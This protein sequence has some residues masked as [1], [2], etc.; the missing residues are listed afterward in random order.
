MFFLFIKLII[1]VYFLV[2]FLRS[3][4]LVWGVGLLSVTTAVLLD[5]F[6][7]TFNRAE[8]LG[9][10]GF[11]F[12][13]LAGGVFGGLAI[14][15]WGVL[16]PY[17]QPP[18]TAVT[19]AAPQP[20]LRRETFQKPADGK[21]HTA[22]DR[23]MLYEEIYKRFGQEDFLDL[24]FD[25]GISDLDLFVGQSFTDSIPEILSLAEKR[26]QTTALALAVERI[27]TPVPKENLPRLEKITADSPATVLRQY[28]LANYDS[29]QL[30]AM[31]AELGVDLEQISNG[32]KK[33]QV[34]DLLLYL[35]RRGRLEELMALLHRPVVSEPAE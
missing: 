32:R 19:P 34:R 26:G 8:M 4:K 6:L 30:Q 35:M 10:L 24:M 17:V 18:V 28:F 16:Q 14:W 1:V 27:L 12:Y 29:Q 5:T 2:M 20:S 25:L 21:T 33:S 7:G 31:A 9:E 3:S 22:T 15:L 13:V 11:F 23:K